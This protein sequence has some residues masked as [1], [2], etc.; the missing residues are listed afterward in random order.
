M[1]SGFEEKSDPAR[2]PGID[3]RRAIVRVIVLLTIFTRR[4]T[5]PTEKA[6]ETQAS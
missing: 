3:G 2:M 1:L 5:I 6:L 4:I